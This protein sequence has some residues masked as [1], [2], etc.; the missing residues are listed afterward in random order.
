VRL[1][2]RV[3]LRGRVGTQVIRGVLIIILVLSRAW[4]GE[5]RGE[6]PSIRQLTKRERDSRQHRATGE[7]DFQ[8]RAE[9]RQ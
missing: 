3:G 2:V 9:V 1:A 4:P 5:G 6:S 8:T 7:E